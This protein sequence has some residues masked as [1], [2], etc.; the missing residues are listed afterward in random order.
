MI[1]KLANMSNSPSPEKI[2][3]PE[4]QETAK[5]L[6]EHIFPNLPQKHFF[7]VGGTA[8]ALKYGHRQSIDFDFFSFPVGSI[9]DPAI[10]KVDQVFREHG[11]YH[12]KDIAPV[13][14]QMHYKINNVSI[15]FAVFQN[16]SAEHEQEFYKI[17]VHQTEKIYG[18]DTL[19]T[20]DLAGMKVFARC[21]RS[22]MKDLVDIAEILHHNIALK[23][24][25]ATA[26]KQFGYDIYE[27]EILASCTEINDIIDNVLDEPITF[28][29]E[30]STGSYIFFLKNQV[31]KLYEDS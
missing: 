18:F 19:S 6:Q 20:L 27:K 10:E 22:K 3:P 30:E 2:L 23:D 9:Q 12:R 15:T 7:L 31:L 1:E 17:P 28:L 24:I 13:S 5:F 29:N 21:H 14:E 16:I 8:L 25:I 11:I 4:Q 26:E